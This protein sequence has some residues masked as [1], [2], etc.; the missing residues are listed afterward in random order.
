MAI[1][2]PIFKLISSKATIVFL[3]I[4]CFKLD[5]FSQNVKT[6]QISHKIYMLESIK[7]FGGG[8]VTVLVGNDGVLLADTMYNNMMV[9]LKQSI[10]SISNKP[11]RI[12]VNS[13]YH[14]DHI[15][16]NLSLKDSA[17]IIAHENV[18]NRLYSKGENTQLFP[19]VTFNDSLNIYFDNERIQI[20]HLPNGHTDGDAIVFFKT[21]KVL[22]TGDLFFNGMF[23]AV[24]A[25]NGGNIT[26]LM[27]SIE[28]LLNNLPPDTKIVPGHGKLASMDDLRFYSRMLKDTYRSIDDSIKD[29]QSLE[30]ILSTNPIEKYNFLGEGGAQTTDQFI[31]MLYTILTTKDKR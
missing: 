29:N 25:K 30:T 28:Y 8:N 18:R 13:H 24:Y 21:S 1:I 2:L 20:L 6:V 9:K 16:G 15:E 31:S 27:S 10:D 7:G 4:L 19:T 22:H 3:I 14:R 23:P 11:I 17:I 5:S 12:V 26:N